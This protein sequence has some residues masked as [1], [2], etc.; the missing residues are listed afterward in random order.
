MRETGGNL[1]ELVVNVVATVPGGE[2]MSATIDHGHF[3][4]AEFQSAV[5]EGIKIG[6]KFA[7]RLDVEAD[8][9]ERNLSWPLDFE[10]DTGV[11]THEPTV[12]QDVQVATAIG[13]KNTTAGACGYNRPC[14]HQ[15]CR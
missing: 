13:T 6:D 8:P 9:L 12:S 3:E 1:Q 14:A 7:V 11:F 2:V 10:F 15:I 5:P 4:G